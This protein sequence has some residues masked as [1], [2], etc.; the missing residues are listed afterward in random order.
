MGTAEIVWMQGTGGAPYSSPA[1]K[2]RRL[3]EVLWDPGVLDGLSVV[4]NHFGANMSVDVNTGHAVIAGTDA[5]GQGSYLFR[6][7]TSVTNVL[8]ATADP[9]NPR[10]DLV[11]VRVQH[12]AYIGA[13][14]S[15]A[16]LDKVTGTPAASPVPPATPTTISAFV[17]FGERC[18]AD[19]RFRRPSSPSSS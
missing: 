13:S 15:N 19:E 17:T 2:D 5:T 12:A 14:N 18:G 1:A 7:T 10:I 6:H 4:Q 11:G 16:I 8:I 3:Y 9:T